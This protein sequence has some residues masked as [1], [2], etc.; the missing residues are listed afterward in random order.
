[1][2]RLSEYVNF[3][4]GPTA[5]SVVP[6][7]N[8]DPP[9]QN[10]AADPNTPATAKLTHGMKMEDVTTLLG[11]GTQL[12]ESVGDGGLKTRVYEYMTTDRRVEITYVDGLVVR[13]S[14]SSK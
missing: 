14:I 7:T 2:Q 12:S 11:P 6:A 4:A 10:A 3:N 13:Y 1:M 9:S 8:G 5:N